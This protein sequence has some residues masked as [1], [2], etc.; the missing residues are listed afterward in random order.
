MINVVADAAALGIDLSNLTLQSVGDG[1]NGSEVVFSGSQQTMQNFV[2]PQSS[3]F[4]QPNTFSCNLPLTHNGYTN[5][6]RQNTVMWS[7]QINTNATGLEIDID[8]W[9]PNAGALPFFPHFFWDDLVNGHLR[10]RDT[11]QNRVAGILD[12]KG[13]DV[14]RC[15]GGQ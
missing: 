5:N 1:K 12:G 7:M 9:N 3:S 4:S 6:C 13:I 10:N 14:P 11:N 2:I 8:R 15:T